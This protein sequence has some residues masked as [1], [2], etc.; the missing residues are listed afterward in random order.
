MIT[1]YAF[2]RVID[3]IADDGSLPEA[4]RRVIL[5]EWKD[6][7]TRGF[8]D[9][10]ELQSEVAGLSSRYAIDPGWLCEIVD[11]VTRDLTHVR[12]ET[13][14]ELLTYCYKVASVVGLVSIEIFGYRNPNCKEYAVNLG[15]ALQLTNIIRDVGEDARNDG[16]I[17][18][19]LEDLRKFGVTESQ[20][21]AHEY[22]VAFENLMQ[23]ECDRARRFYHLAEQLLPEEDRSNMLAAEIMA[24]VYGEILTKIEKSKS[25][26]FEGRIGLSKTRK[27]IILAAYALRGLLRAV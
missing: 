3:D 13:F 27:C 5:Q 20:I 17:Y 4:E 22:S 11:G 9:P 6:G 1:F 15:Y 21:L 8:N 25:H 12:Y 23:F 19:P 7:L 10:D 26:V 2:C 14:T 18:L 16:R 24:Q